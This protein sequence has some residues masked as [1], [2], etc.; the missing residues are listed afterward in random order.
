MHKD[1]LRTL[2]SRMLATYMS[3]TLGMLLLSGVIAGTL[4]S[5][6]VMREEKQSIAN[7]IG[8]VTDPTPVVLEGSAALGAALRSRQVDSSQISG[9]G[10]LG[11]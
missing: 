5:G 7:E 6:F 2:F 4:M 11:R 1:F 9:N 8:I 10:G 3:V